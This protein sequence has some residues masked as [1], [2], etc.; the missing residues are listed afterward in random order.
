MLNKNVL[1][2]VSIYF[3]DVCFCFLRGLILTKTARKKLTAKYPHFQHQIDQD[4]ELCSSFQ[5]TAEASVINESVGSSDE[6]DE[7][8]TLA[9]D[10]INAQH[11]LFLDET[12]EYLEAFLKKRECRVQ[13]SLVVFDSP[14]DDEVIVVDDEVTPE[15]KEDPYWYLLKNR[16]VGI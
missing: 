16:R 1:H 9:S 12:V 11:K 5:V 6:A 8:S 3:A 4:I 2:G 15:A 7:G 10:V 13:S 14:S